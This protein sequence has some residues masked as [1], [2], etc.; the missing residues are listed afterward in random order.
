MHDINIL[1]VGCTKQ[2]QE[3]ML[4]ITDQP[5]AVM[6]AESLQRALELLDE[7]NV[8]MLVI[9]RKAAAHERKVLATHARERGARVLLIGD[10]HDA[11][12]VPMD[13]VADSSR[14]SEF[15]GAA[16]KLASQLRPQ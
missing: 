1:T 2:E 9:G 5:H 15:I 14:P 3:A 12:G 13:I 11:L 6:M 10:T 16:E 7:N 8:Q 4:G